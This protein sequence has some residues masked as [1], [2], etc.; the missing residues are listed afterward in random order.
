MRVVEKEALKLDKAKP[1]WFEHINQDRLSLMSDYNCVIGQ[2]YGHWGEGRPKRD[3][4][5]EYSFTYCGIGLPKWKNPP[6]ILAP[7]LTLFFF[8][9]VILL[10]VPGMLLDLILLPL[11]KRAWKQ[12]INKRLEQQRHEESLY[13]PFDWQYEQLKKERELA[14]H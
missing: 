10:F 7:I 2:V 3:G 4:I 14:L 8:I 1:H 9:S 13:V 5:D 11:V 12:E 6:A